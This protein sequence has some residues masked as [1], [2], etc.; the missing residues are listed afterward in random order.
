MRSRGQ[1]PLPRDQKFSRAYRD[2][3]LRHPCR[4]T[5]LQPLRAS[6]RP[7]PRRTTRS[8]SLRTST[9]SF[10]GSATP[11]SAP[12]SSRTEPTSRAFSR[13]SGSG[14]TRLLPRT[15]L[16]FGSSSSA[17]RS[18]RRRR[19]TSRRHQFQACQSLRYRR[20]RACRA[21]FRTTPPQLP[22]EAPRG[23]RVLRL[24]ENRRA[25][26]VLR[27]RQSSLRTRLTPQTSTRR[28]PRP[29]PAA[30]RRSRSSRRKTTSNLKTCSAWDSS[31]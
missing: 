8:A 22:R 20:A 16:R 28:S 29:C 9:T 24:L 31:R 17:S 6:S 14:Q 21:R 15:R 19:T 7:R 25:T 27:R 11:S 12:S 4:I 13:V 18:W 10:S 5:T 3:K 2:R 30:S 23:L 26:L 1:L